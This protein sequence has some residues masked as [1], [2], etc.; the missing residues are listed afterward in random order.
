MFDIVLPMVPPYGTY[1][2]EF[3]AG[4]FVILLFLGMVFLAV[5]A[6]KKIWRKK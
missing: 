2:K 4:Y 5:I 1:G 6:I 3:V